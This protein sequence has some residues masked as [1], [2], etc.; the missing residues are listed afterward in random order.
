MT[1]EEL[2]SIK[3]RVIDE[4]LKLEDISDELY[5]SDKFKNYVSNS[6]L[7]LI[8]PT[9]GGNPDKYFKGV[10]KLFTESLVFGTLVHQLVLQPD[11]FLLVEEV[12]LPPGKPGLIAELAYSS[13][14]EL[15]HDNTLLDYCKL[16]DFWGGNPSNATFSKMKEQIKP[17]IKNR[18]KYEEEYYST[19]IGKGFPKLVYV[20]PANLERINPCIES[21][22]NNS[23]IQ[24]L[25]HPVDLMGE[26]LPNSNEATILLDVE[27]S[28]PG[29]DPVVLHLKSKLDNYSID[30]MSNT[31]K[32]NDVKTTSSL[33]Y[34]DFAI[35]KYHYYRE[36]GMYSWL[37]SKCAKE[38]FDLNNPRIE[39]N[40]LVVE[41]KPE[42]GSKVT[43]CTT[44]MLKAG[45]KE[46]IYLLRLVAYHSMHDYKSY[47]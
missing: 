7:K 42:F 21:I 37:L 38:M 46:F 44:A 32:V 19:H 41:T 17:F 29:C 40:F 43:P 28:M 5:F 3:F 2:S 36:M 8:N 9:E 1:K 30:E 23:K 13:S 15:P 31:I 12:L 11:D 47:V 20:N 27:A 45:M 6:R 34:F 33:N 39:S 24:E 10:P 18:A 25:L 14:G 35:K 4:S 16:V 22:K 26:S